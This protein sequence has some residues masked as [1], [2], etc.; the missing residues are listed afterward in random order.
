MFLFCLQR[1]VA[2]LRLNTARL[3]VFAAHAKR[4]SNARMSSAMSDSRML[5]RWNLTKEDIQREAND[6]MRVSRS[7]F[8]SVGSLKREDVTFDR[9]VKIL[10]D[11]KAWYD[12]RRSM[13]DFLQ[14]V[15]TD[16]E[17][18]EVSTEADKQLSEFDV[19]M[20]MRQDVFDSLVAFKETAPALAPEAERYLNRMIVN[21]RRNGLHLSPE[22]QAKVKEIKTKLSDLSITFTKNL[23]EENTTLRFVED[24]LDG[25]PADFVKSLKRTDDGNQ[26]EVTL[27]YP[28]YFPFM[29]HAK[30]AESRRRLNVAFL[31]RCKDENTKILQELVELRKEMADTLGYPTH[32]SYI[33]ELRMAK[34]VETVDKFLTEL[35]GQMKPLRDRDLDVFRE[36]KEAECTEQGHKYDNQINNW[37]MRYYMERVQERQYSV[38][39]EKLKEYF[40]LNIVT[41]GLLAIYQELLNLK[42]SAVSGAEVWHEDVTMYSV[43]DAKSDELMGWFYLDLHPREGKFGHAA[44]FGLQP[45]CLLPDGTRQPAVAAMVANFTKPTVDHPAL[46]LHDEVETF[47]HEFGHVM[48][49]ICAQADY[50]LFSGTSVERDFVEAPSQML[51]NWCW[52]KESLRRMSSHYKDGSP[53]PEE[54]LDKLI[55]SRIA[56]SGVF[57]CRQLTFALFDQAI[58]SRA[59]V[60]I[61]ETYAQFTK[62]ILGIE[63]T[64]GTSFPATFG[65][66][67]GGYDAQYYGYLWSEVFSADMFHS[68][69]KSEGIMNPA[70]GADYRRCILRPGGSKDGMD[71]LKD[72]LGREPSQEAFYV[73]KGLTV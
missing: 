41:T 33:T 69:F 14:H 54:L 48:H 60:D 70:T 18:R 12:T 47:F 73:S 30:R 71:M 8:N 63:A 49:Q 68:R 13:L 38:D 10:A 42:F 15:S 59:N 37:D 43:T 22:K 39:Q 50:A 27:K 5:L 64:P 31:S 57:N 62:D 45:S 29:K 51:E 21:G 32:A 52:E 25:L 55:A 44:C 67:A 28:H 2:H 58:H 61:V 19:E 20:S 40:P 26:Y 9:T 53:I 34:T 66:L 65:H 56:N 3:V 4:A 36:Y 35:A 72:F 1:K 16:K 24:D 11:N 7:A 6:L 46:L 23:G 17:I